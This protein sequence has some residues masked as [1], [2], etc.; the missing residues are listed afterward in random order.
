MKKILLF[1]MI[2]LILLNAVSAASINIV[3]DTSNK[4]FDGT[5]WQNAVATWVHGSWPS[6]SGAT[7][8]WNSN[9]ITDPSQDETVQFQKS[10]ELPA[11][12]AYTGNIRITTDNEYILKINGNN[13]G[14]DT[15]WQ[16]IETY[17]ID[18]YLQHG[19]NLIEI[20]A[21]NRKC[22]TDNIPPDQCNAYNNPAGV[23]YSADISY[24]D[25]AEVPEFT[26]VGATLAL[27]GAGLYV[28]KK[29]KQ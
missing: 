6:I 16:N 2:P 26:T 3:S 23:L 1:M 10:F 13:V 14:S 27:V 5:N 19:T 18:S 20:E 28:Y 21:K 8:I 7:W 11:C 9:L 29:K 25:Q 15:N 4:Y 12:N 24:C 22:S 17:N